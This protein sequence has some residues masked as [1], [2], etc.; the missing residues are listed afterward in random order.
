MEIHSR[1]R[2]TL[3]TRL[4]RRTVEKFRVV[5]NEAMADCF[6]ASR[7]R[8]L[9]EQSDGAVQAEGRCRK[10]REVSVSR[11]TRGPNHSGEFVRLPCIS[12]P[13]GVN[14][15]G[16]PVGLQDYARRNEDALLLDWRW[17]FERARP[18]RWCARR[19]RL[20]SGYSAPCM[21]A[22]FVR[23]RL[24]RKRAQFDRDPRSLPSLLSILMSPPWASTM[25][26]AMAR[27]RPV[28]PS[29]RERALSAR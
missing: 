1:C 6:R 20:G 4:A 10:R 24:L 15:N 16:L 13:A 9:R 8:A 3:S 19:S 27:P 23:G 12:I 22:H 18:W 7:H 29:S 17:R 28:P 14:S 21:A 11:T 26:R 25:W 2:P 5:M